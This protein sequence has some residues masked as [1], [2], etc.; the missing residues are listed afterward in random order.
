MAIEGIQRTP[1]NIELHPNL[2][3][4]DGLAKIGILLEYEFNLG[5][6]SLVL[7]GC[8]ERI[9]GKR[10]LRYYAEDLV[11]LLNFIRGGMN[12]SDALVSCQ[13]KIADKTKIH[14]LV[15]R[16]GET[17]ETEASGRRHYKAKG[18]ALAVIDG[19]DRVDVWRTDQTD[20]AWV[21]YDAHS[22]TESYL[23][24]YPNWT[25]EVRLQRAHNYATPIATDL[26]RYASSWK[27]ISNQYKGLGTVCE[28]GYSKLLMWDGK[29]DY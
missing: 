19:T 27:H 23:R 16:W 7:E 9:P 8:M 25:W 12:P 6:R 17:A 29:V 4:M 13:Q 3:K 10:E 1:D 14:A 18:I 15:M 11:F 26:Y 22:K 24:D 28:G 2:Q 21:S 5:N 20:Q